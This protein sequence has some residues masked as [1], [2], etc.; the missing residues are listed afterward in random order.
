MN[1]LVA[2]EE[3]QRVC[4]ELRKLGVNAFSC[5]IQECS[6][7]HPEWHIMQDVLSLLHPP[8]E[9]NTVD[10]RSH[11]VEKWDL[12]IAHPPC[13]Y[14]TVSGNRWFDETKYGENA[15]RRKQERESNSVLPGIRKC[16]LPS[17]SH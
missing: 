8:C 1:A 16:G 5:D 15:V 2:C 14:L 17:Y 9:F 12:L 11:R 7:G 4:T 3:S 13:T 10:G 6:G